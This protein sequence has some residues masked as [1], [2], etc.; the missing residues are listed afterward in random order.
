MNETIK[1]LV[2]RRSCK[3]FDSTKFVEKE[4]LDLILKAG[5]YA[6]NGKG[7]QSSTIV[8]VENQNTIKE[9]SKLN[10]EILGNPNIDPFYGATCVLVVFADPIAHTY[11]EDGSLVIG[12]LMNAAFSL[13]VDS[14]WIH[15]AKEMFLTEKGKKIKKEWGIAENLVGIGNCVLGY[16]KTNLP[17][18]KPRKENYVIY[19]A[20]KII[21]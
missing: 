17:P 11:V 21:D 5:T 15:R 20:D 4:K 8:V 18:A 16:R 14:C 2:E 1:T 7:L 3:N 9:L 13:G 19:A 10:A 6:A 12:N